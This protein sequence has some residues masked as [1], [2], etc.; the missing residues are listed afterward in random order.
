[1]GLRESVTRASVHLLAHTLF[2]LR[3]VGRTHLPRQGAALL[4]CNHLSFADALLVQAASARPISFLTYTPYTEHPSLQWLFRLMGAI[5]VQGPVS[6]N[7][8]ALLSARSVLE[9]GG[10][11]CLFTE[12]AA[13]RTGGLP[14]FAPAYAQLV[15]GLDIPVVPVYLDRTFGSLLAFKGRR[16]IST[17]P[18]RVPYPVT[19]AFGAPLPSSTPAARTRLALLELGSEVSGERHAPDD[20]LG[21]AFIRTAKRRF[22]AFSLADSTGRRLTFGRALVASLLLARWL[23]RHTQGQRA[24]GLL[25]PSSVGG[26]LA[27]TATSLAGKIAVNLN[28][29]AGTDAMA[30]AVGACE[31]QTILTSK[32]FLAKAGLAQMPGMVYLEDILPTVVRPAAAL[33]TLV[34]S[35]FLP[36]RALLRF[37]GGAAA[38]CDDTA[39]I[40]FSSGSTGA[41]KGVVL[42]HR[43]ILSN[44]D[45]IEQI[46]EFTHHDV[47]MGVLPFFHSFGYTGTMWF[48]L[49]SGFGVVFHP[50]PT[51]AKTI[52]ELAN[53][54]RATILISTPTFCGAYARKVPPAHFA[55]L[56]YA[57]VGAEKL[58]EPVARAFKERFGVTLLEGY[59]CTELAPVVSANMPETDERGQARVGTKAGSVGHPMPGIAAKVVDADTGE[60]PLFATEGLL[61][62]KGPNRMQGYLGDPV[63]TAEAIRDGWYV[64]GDVAIVDEDGFIFITDRLARFSKIAGEMVPHGRLEDVIATFLSDAATVSVTSVPDDLK[65]ERLVAFYTDHTLSPG[66]LWDR[67]CRTELPKL[68]IPKRDDLRVVDAIPALGTGKVDLRALRQLA[69]AASLPKGR[70]EHQPS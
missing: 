52:G 34:M 66:D 56:R 25:L 28:F 64:T 10:L 67:L 41:P 50:N 47:L 32:Q 19:V 53:E 42:T 9:R 68:W 37:C 40:I 39:T 16:F 62:I 69:M 65:G 17:P 38:R 55:S 12:G 20:T 11:V 1:M 26:A 33:G 59:G 14:P 54:H 21:S 35:L 13:N 22:F 6:D 46:I 48:P 43:N 2:R 27:N 51:D 70:A 45:G 8:S 3:A 57:I 49:T 18:S 29:T 24:I 23:Q 61:L 5:P 63:R 60:G 58:R 36:A 44:L 31:I 30:H 4:V 7:A 15:E